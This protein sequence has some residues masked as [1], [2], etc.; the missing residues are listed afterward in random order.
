MPA[1]LTARQSGVVTFVVAKISWR[2]F[3]EPLV[4]RG[5]ARFHH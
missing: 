2:F 4:A 3:E 5:H 1:S